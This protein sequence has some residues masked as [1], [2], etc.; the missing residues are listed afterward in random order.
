D[1]GGGH[2]G[3]DHGGGHEGMDHGGHHMHHG[4]SV[5]GLAMADTGPDRDGLQLD[6]LTVALGPVLLGWPT[7]LVVQARLQGDVVV[8]AESSWVDGLVDVV[9]ERDR[10]PRRVALD[11]LAHFL[12]LAGWPTASREARRA[13]DG[14][15]ELD[16]AAVAAAQKAAARL[17]RRVARSRTFA[18][19]VSGLGVVGASSPGGRQGD[20]LDRV[21]R[22]CAVAA[23]EAGDDDLTSTPVE[24]LPVLLEGMELAAARLVVASLS[25]ERQPAP[26]RGE[27]LH[28]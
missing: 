10:N 9:A 17:A 24:E 1:H 14:L 11:H 5:A 15:G 27:G 22:W 6:V 26:A 3:M 16:P 13:R 7:G 19:S 18:W 20:V 21:R 25:L 2:E 8:D 12:L 28:D 4:G 23:G